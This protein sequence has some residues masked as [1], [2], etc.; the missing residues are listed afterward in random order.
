MALKTSRRR[1]ANRSAKRDS[2]FTLPSNPRTSNIFKRVASVFVGT[3]T[4]DYEMPAQLKFINLR[5]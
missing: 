5:Q 1:A 4:R 2:R 3:R